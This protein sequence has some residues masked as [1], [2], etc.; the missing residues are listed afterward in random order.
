MKK[1]KNREKILK[2]ENEKIEKQI[3]HMK[4]ELHTI[5]KKKVKTSTTEVDL[6]KT[7]NK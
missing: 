1:W 5:K 3:I 4:K 7:Y 6:E 2:L